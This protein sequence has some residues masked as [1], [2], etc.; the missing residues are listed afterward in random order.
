MM[1]AQLAFIDPLSRHPTFSPTLQ[2][3]DDS[4]YSLGGEARGCGKDFVWVGWSLVA[5]RRGIGEVRALELPPEQEALVLGGNCLRLIHRVKRQPVNHTPLIM[6]RARFTPMATNFA[7]RGRAR[8]L[9]RCS[10]RMSVVL[11]S[12]CAARRICSARSV[13]PSL[14]AAR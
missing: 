12:L 1:A 13:T 2:V 6:D 14:M 7:I 5:P 9:R 3:C 11:A 8:L 4:T 10:T